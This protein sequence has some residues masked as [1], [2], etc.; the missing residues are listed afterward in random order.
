MNMLAIISALNIK[1]QC[2]MECLLCATLQ[3][4]AAIRTACPVHRLF[5][6][7]SRLDLVF[8]I[9]A[10]QPV[11][12]RGHKRGHIKLR[13]IAR[14]EL[15]FQED[16]EY[17]PTNAPIVI[18]STN[19]NWRGKHCVTKWRK[20]PSVESTLTETFNYWW[21]GISVECCV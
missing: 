4:Q 3:K 15:I 19:A 10:N 1:S 12:H 2:L 5:H 16:S 8:F 21:L 13:V 20:P 11:I 18:S 6:L 9:I 17:L 7:C 14:D